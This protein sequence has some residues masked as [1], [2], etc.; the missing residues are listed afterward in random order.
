MVPMNDQPPPVRVL[1]VDDDALVRAGLRMILSADP[2]ID[3]VGEAADG[4]AA[5]TAAA[6][7]RPDVVLM[8]IRMP[9]MDGI[10]ATGHLHQ[11][12]RAPQVIVL[13][14][15]H[16]DDYVFAALRAGASGFLLKDTAPTNIINAV[17]TVARGE[18][19]LSPAVIRTLIEH[20]TN[21][22]ADSRRATAAEQLTALTD[23]ERQVAVEIGQGH[24]NADI[25]SHLYMSEATVKGH[26]SRLLTKLHATNRVQI[27]I[28]VH[29]AGLV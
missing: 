10:T 8:D 5:L 26:V 15:F 13:T 2:T 3:V 16:L 1:L 9:D 21:D 7:L 23:R 27:A 4:Q 25:A 22:H 17:H 11:L 14:T 19:M 20:F 28:V 24:S 12:P 18:A 29:D 6:D